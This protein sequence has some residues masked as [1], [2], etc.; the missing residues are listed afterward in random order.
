MPTPRRG[1]SQRDYVSRCVPIRQHEH[2]EESRER[3]VAACYGMF[4]QHRKK[5]TR[6]ESK[7]KN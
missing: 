2:P 4:K 6:Y 5:G 3:S 7:K 1:E